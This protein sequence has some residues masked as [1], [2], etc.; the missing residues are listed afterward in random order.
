MAADPVTSERIYASLKREVMSGVFAPSEVLVE[1]RI[2][3]DFGV[4]ITPVRAAAHRL[5]GERMLGLNAGGGFRI[6]EVTEGSLRELYFWHGQLV[7]NAV[8]T[9][10]QIPLDRRPLIMGPTV[11]TDT[12]AMTRGLFER[13]AIRSANGEILAAIRS[14]GER[15]H[16]A[17]LRESWVMPG[18]ED[19]LAEVQALTEQ[20]SGQDLLRALWAYHRRRLRRI[21]ELVAA[22]HLP[23]G[24]APSL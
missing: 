18:I 7:R 19:E 17:R 24:R 14:A 10:D 21:S 8:S 12:A 5:V 2:A 13:I 20:G 23:L 4:S 3:A 1:R 15:L 16:G 22:L 11:F 6:P 9:G